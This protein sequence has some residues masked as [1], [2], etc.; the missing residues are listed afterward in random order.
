MQWL[1]LG[2]LAA[3]VAVLVAAEWPRLAVHL[4]SGR[5]G[6]SVARKP[7]RRRR[8]SHLALV[9]DENM[10]EISDNEREAFTESVVRDL[11]RLPTIDDHNDR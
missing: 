7:G 4:A 10:D 11:E 5:D 6:S 1:V 8:R 3:A 2:L 9:E